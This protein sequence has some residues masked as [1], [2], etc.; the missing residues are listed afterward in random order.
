MSS[1]TSAA[2]LKATITSGSSFYQLTT[3]NYSTTSLGRVLGA[4]QPAY[5]YSI[6]GTSQ[7]STP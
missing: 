2:S 6:S 4:Y 3:E 5:T 1:V 7:S